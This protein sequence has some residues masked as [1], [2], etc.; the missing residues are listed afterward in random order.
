M[1]EF[2]DVTDCL[3]FKT[4]PDAAD[5]NRL[6]KQLNPKIMNQYQ[7]VDKAHADYYHS[8]E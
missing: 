7:I 5:W 1:R 2:R 3:L 4:I 6:I 8:P